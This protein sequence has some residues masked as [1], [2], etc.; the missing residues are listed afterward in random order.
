VHAADEWDEN[1]LMP[2]AP[3]PL[4]PAAAPKAKSHAAIPSG[5]KRRSGVATPIA[6]ASAAAPRAA[7]AAGGGGGARAPR[8]TNKAASAAEAAAA[9]LE[10]ETAD[11]EGYG[12]TSASDSE[13]TPQPTRKTATGGNAGA[14]TNQLPQHGH[15][16]GVV[17]ELAPRTAHTLLAAGSQSVRLSQELVKVPG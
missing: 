1:S 11:E 4:L 9:A 17:Y 7:A 2:F 3:N 5:A 16:S 14:G 15:P 13:H 12:A 8:T 6:S 10:P